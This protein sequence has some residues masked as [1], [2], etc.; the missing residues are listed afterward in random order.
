MVNH[1][2]RPT[3]TRSILPNSSPGILKPL[4]GGFWTC[5]HD[6]LDMH[7]LYKGFARLAGHHN[8][9]S[10]YELAMR[11]LAGNTERAIAQFD[12]IK[13]CGGV[14]YVTADAIKGFTTEH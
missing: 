10:C 5:W 2:N 6:E 12:Y 3:R 11:I 14:Q 13:A 9:Y 1:P 8:G 4:E 7:V